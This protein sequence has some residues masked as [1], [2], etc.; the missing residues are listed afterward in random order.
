M[1]T[2]FN[3]QRKVSSFITATL[4]AFSLTASIHAAEY[5]LKEHTIQ[6]TGSMPAQTHYGL[7]TPQ[8]ATV[9][10]SEQGVIEKL[11]IILDMDSIDVTDLK[12]GKMRNKL[13]KHLRS[14]D[15][16]AVEAHPTAEFELTQHDGDKVSGHLTIR[17][18]TKA[19]EFPVTVSRGADGAW[20]LSGEL[21][22]IRQDFNVK[23]QN[24]GFFSTAKEKLIR[25]EVQVAVQLVVN[26]AS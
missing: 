8:Q 24:K 21:E 4:L 15:F 10:I 17:G 2:K 23:Y 19:V 1:N 20:A 11:H 25:D 12:E 22:F 26:P 9:S 13:M 7:L 18:I 16:F 6:W 3:I 14:D 5:E